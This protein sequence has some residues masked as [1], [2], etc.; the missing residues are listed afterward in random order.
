MLHRD[1]L[2]PSFPPSPVLPPALP[3]ALPPALPLSLPHLAPPRLHKHRLRVPGAAVPLSSRL[4]SGL[5]SFISIDCGYQGRPYPSPLG[6]TWLHKHRLRVPGAAVALSSRLHLAARFPDR[7]ISIDCGYQGRPYPSPLNFTW[8][9]DPPTV[10]GTPA[11]ITRISPD[12]GNGRP[13]PSPLNFTWQPDPPT[14]PGTPAVITGISP[15]AGDVR[16]TT[17]LSLRA[18][19]NDRDVNCYHVPLTAAGRYLVRLAFWYKN[20]DGKNSPPVFNVTIGP[21][22]A[23]Q[24]DLRSIGDTL[25][26]IEAIATVRDATMPICLQR[27][28]DAPPIINA[29]EIRPLP[30]LSYSYQQLKADVLLVW[31]RFAC[32]DSPVRDQTFR[33]PPPPT[34]P[35]P[36]IIN[37]IEIRPLPPPSYSYQQLKADVLLVWW[38]FT[39][40]DSPVRDQTFRYPS[41]P[42]DRIWQIDGSTQL[43]YWDLQ[44]STRTQL[45]TT[46]VTIVKPTRPRSPLSPP[47]FRYPSDPAD[48]IWQIDGS[49]QLDHW[50]L[51]PSNLTQLVT[52]N[53]TVTI[54]PPSPPNTATGTPIPSSSSV[55]NAVPQRVLQSARPRAGQAAIPFTVTP[56][57]RLNIRLRVK[58]TAKS[59]IRP[60]TLSGLE[61]VQLF[62]EAPAVGGGDV[63]ALACVKTQFGE[64]AAMEEWVG[65]PC[66]PVTWPGV[67]CSFSANATAVIGLDLSHSG[68]SGSIPACISNLSSL[69]A[70]VLND[71]SLTGDIPSPHG[72]PHLPTPPPHVPSPTKSLTCSTLNDNSLT[73][74]IPSWLGSLSNLHSLYGP[75]TLCLPSSLSLPV[76]ASSLPPLLTSPRGLVPSR[77]CTPCMALLPSPNPRLPSSPPLVPS[78]HPLLIL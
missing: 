59:R 7:F 70:L 72:Q 77:I 29:I 52:T 62:E 8:Q 66:Y 71:N 34:L 48:R 5:K 54:P 36:P 17:E 57:N 49:T 6:F 47:P 67:Q 9:P 21:G 32:G 31:W 3:T 27:V 15:E 78:P 73:G 18:F 2:R 53:A 74:D 35:A 37:A 12:A 19:N 33:K 4:L 43:D 1:R 46:N 16:L 20:Y 75:P 42:A 55:L 50:D 60:V 14:V 22:S 23:G 68:L 24:V 44:P 51:Q 69:S 39:C 61:I 40:G 58:T 25:Y 65:D 64:P 45:V 30:P 26:T 13:Y 56:E 38:R 41:D 63:A 10:S 11:V 28:G 76:R